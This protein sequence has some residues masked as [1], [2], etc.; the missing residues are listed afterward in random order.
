M[1]AKMLLTVRLLF[2]LCC[3]AETGDLSETLGI[4]SSF[5][6]M[7]LNKYNM[8][9]EAIDCKEIY[10]SND[11]NGDCFEVES[12]QILMF[13][14]TNTMRLTASA[15]GGANSPAREKVERSESYDRPYLHANIPM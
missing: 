11:T 13:L 12:K 14:L 9:F 1:S 2:I 3:F 6:P 7:T 15:G 8:M 4:S 5:S 10:F